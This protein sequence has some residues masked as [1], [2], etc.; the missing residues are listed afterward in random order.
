MWIG[1]NGFIGQRIHP[2]PQRYVLATSPKIIDASL[3]QNR[4]PLEIL[5]AKRVLDRLIDVS[6]PFKPLGGETME[7]GDLFWMCSMELLAQ[8]FGE[9]MMVT[10]PTPIVIERD[11]EEVGQIKI[12]Q[13]LLPIVPTG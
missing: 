13:G 9:Q 8:H 3:N 5:G 10:V 4:R 12:L 6:V 2:G 7:G 1:E 11:N